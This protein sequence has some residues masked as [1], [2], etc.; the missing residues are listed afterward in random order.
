EELILRTDTSKYPTDWSRDGQS[1]LYTDSQLSNDVWVLPLSGDRKP[2]PF[3]TTPANE[4]R[5]RF[6]PD[7]HWIA[8][9]SDE[10]GN[11]CVYVQRFPASGGKWQVS[12]GAGVEPHWRGDGRELYY[13]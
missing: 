11:S 3:L 10:S 2:I 1:L 4:N 13:S 7:G 6:S 8:Y 9:T 5:A 12:E